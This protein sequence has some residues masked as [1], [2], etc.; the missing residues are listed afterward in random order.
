MT[1]EQTQEYDDALV[2]LLQLVW[3]DGFMSPG[4]PDEIKMI[5]QA[6][7]LTGKSVLDI[8]CGTGGITKFLADKFAPAKVVGIDVDPGLIERAEKRWD[9]T[10]SV[11]WLSYECVAPGKLPF[12]DGS[13]DVVFSKDSMLHIED[14]EA[15]FADIYR[16]LSPG[17]V[18]AASDWLSSTEPP[19]SKQMAYY[20]DIEGL[21][22]SMASP[23]RYRQA[24]AVAGFGDISL[25]DRNAWYRSI[26][27]M[28][29]QAVRGHLYKEIIALAGQDFADEAVEVWRA[30]TVV[31]GSGEL[32]PTH[33]YAR[34]PE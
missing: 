16:V 14:K 26:A 28:E 8:G 5:V 25:T 1:T 9:G 18:I 23:D 17:G 2:A 12:E 19:F 33:I 11:G 6:A 30:L 15:L 7:D 21:G 27:D 34:K 20:I 32:L 3:G 22:F 31:V 13:F 4:G 10:Q 24:L 29:Y